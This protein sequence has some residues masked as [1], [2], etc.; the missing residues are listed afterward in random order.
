MFEQPIKKHKSSVPADY[1][2]TAKNYFEKGRNVEETKHHCSDLLRL[3]SSSG[4]NYS[5]NGS[6]C[7]RAHKSGIKYIFTPL[8]D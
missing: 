2:D 3:T 6:Q 7:A 8:Q 1:L 4:I 5:S